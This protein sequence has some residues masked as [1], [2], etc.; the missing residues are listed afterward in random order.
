MYNIAVIL[1]GVSIVISIFLLIVTVKAL[2]LRRARIFRYTGAVF[3]V[4]LVSN[5]V[6]VLQVFS[7]LPG[8][9]YE[10]ISFLSVELIILLL[11]YTG[12][13]RGIG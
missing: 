8:A 4:I 11:F 5:C 3:A 9:R 1:S 10:V 12:I 7:L 2:R 6:Y 13:A